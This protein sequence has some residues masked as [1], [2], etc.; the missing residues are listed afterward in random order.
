MEAL[1][2]ILVARF[3]KRGQSPLSGQSV[4]MRE[5]SNRAQIGGFTPIYVGGCGW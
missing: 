5:R 1:A 4:L 3:E 2:R